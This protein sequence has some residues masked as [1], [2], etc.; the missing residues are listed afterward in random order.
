MVGK[1]IFVLPKCEIIFG[2]II[3]LYSYRF[4]NFAVAKIVGNHNFVSICLVIH[5][6]LS[7]FITNSCESNSY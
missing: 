5:N 7:I 4:S 1:I 6:A 2:G 3:L